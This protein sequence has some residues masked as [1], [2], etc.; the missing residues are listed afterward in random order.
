LAYFGEDAINK[1][2]V[3]Q[4]LDCHNHAKI[5][6][7]AMILIPQVYALEEITSM[8]NE[9]SRELDVTVS[10][11]A[12]FMIE[13]TQ[14]RSF[15]LNQLKKFKELNYVFLSDQIWRLWFIALNDDSEVR[16]S[17]EALLAKIKKECGNN[18]IL[19]NHVE[20]MRNKICKNKN[21]N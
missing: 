4:L 14:S 17:L 3:N 21:S 7:A 8:V 15:A 6:R 10:R 5:R 12:N 19:M 1:G 13:L 2:Q 11:M 16:K 9:L 18:K 20:I